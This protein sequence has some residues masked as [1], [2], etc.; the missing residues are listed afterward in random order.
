MQNKGKDF[1]CG[2]Q[3]GK[4]LRRY[5]GFA[6]L[7]S[8]PDEKATSAANQKIFRVGLVFGISFNQPD[9]F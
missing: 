4:W 3:A 9:S 2:F 1:A 7:H 8:R 5:R 6:I